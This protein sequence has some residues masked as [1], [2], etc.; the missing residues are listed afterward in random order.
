M[1]ILVTGATGFIGLEV[2]KQ[3]CLNGYRPR[4]MVRRPQRGALLSRMDVEIAQGDLTSYK[5]LLRATSGIDV[6]IHLGARATFED[7]KLLRKT[8][9]DGSLNLMKACRESGVRSFIFSSSML[10]YSSTDEL[11]DE[12]TEA[13]P[14]VDYGMAK[15]ET[16]KML[17]A[18]AQK[19]GINFLALRLPHIY[20][21]QDL[22]FGQLKKGYFVL[23]GDGNNY[24][25]HL[26]VEDTARM[27]VRA[28]EKNITGIYPVSDN[29]ARTWNDFFS[30]LKEFYPYFRLVKI[31]EKLATG[32]MLLYRPV[33]II[34]KTPSLYTRDTIKSF[35]LNLNV[36]P[37]ILW[38]KLGI[39]PKYKTVEDGIPATLDG[40]VAFRWKSPIF[41]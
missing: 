38:D 35:N 7:Y 12:S 5:S 11:I 19:S 15:L 25:S 28:F 29:G 10:V 23:P 39:E 27:I 32:M 14:A 13:H 26:H 18:E 34:T 9:V 24:F 37:G 30:Y 33:H 17:K 2:A 31:P 1:N 40:F 4:L 3:L 20:G 21:P 6:V 36:K 41:D 22:M 8:N 16:E